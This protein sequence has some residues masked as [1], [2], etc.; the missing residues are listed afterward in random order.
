MKKEQ[1]ELLLTEIE[2]LQTLPVEEREQI[3]LD[4]DIAYIFFS[5]STEELLNDY[6]KSIIFWYMDLKEMLEEEEYT[7]SARLRDVIAFEQEEFK[8]MIK[9]Y[10]K[11]PNRSLE[12][13]TEAVELVNE[14]TKNK[15][16]S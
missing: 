16:I 10:H 13:I 4:N 14:Y 11:S 12:E 3:E 2:F 8:R 6:I 9:T 15:F 1:I 5:S 7:T